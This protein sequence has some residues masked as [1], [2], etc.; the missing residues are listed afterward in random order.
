MLRPNV[1]V[2]LSEAMNYADIGCQGSEIQS[3]HLNRL[4]KDGLRFTQ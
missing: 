2:T 3:P 1:V 4:A